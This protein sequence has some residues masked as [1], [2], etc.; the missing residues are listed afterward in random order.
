M[1]FGLTTYYT[2]Y[3]DDRD[4]LHL[5]TIRMYDV[6]ILTANGKLTA[7]CAPDF[8]GYAPLTDKFFHSP[9]TLETPGKVKLIQD[10][11]RQQK[12][13]GGVEGSIKSFTRQELQQELQKVIARRALVYMQQTMIGATDAE[14][15]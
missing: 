12:W 2:G 1:K 8:F 9:K 5:V 15:E 6:S 14:D 4:A 13:A 10:W 3:R 11:F 7:V